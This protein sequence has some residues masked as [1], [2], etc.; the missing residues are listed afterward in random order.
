MP[1]NQPTKVK[2]PNMPPR[3]GATAL[4]EPV[5]ESQAVIA[6]RFI[7]VIVALAATAILV[8]KHLNLWSA[9]G[10]GAGGGCDK[11]ATS[12]FG[13]VAFINWPTP[14]G[15]PVSFLGFTYYLSLLVSLVVTQGKVTPVMKH[16]ARLGALA[17]AFFLFIMLAN[18]NKYFC[19]YCLASHLANF[20]FLATVEVAKNTAPKG[21]SW[22]TLGALVGAFVLTTGGLVGAELAAE[23]KR[24]SG[25]GDNIA[26]MVEIEKAKEAARQNQTPPAPPT[27]PQQTQQA[28]ST[29]PQ[30]P[31]QSTQNTQ[32]QPAPTPQSDNSEA[33]IAQA[34]N[35]VDYTTWSDDQWEQYAKQKGL[36]PG[37]PADAGPK[38]GFTGQYRIGPS[39]ATIRIVSFSDY[40]CPD[41]KKVEAQ[42]EEVLK[43]RADISF[44]H[45]HFAF[46]SACNPHFKNP[47]SPHPNSCWA[48]RA[49]E[50][51][52]LVRGNRGFWE[53]H[54]WLFSRGGAFTD[55][56]MAQA[57]RVMN[58]EPSAFQQLMKEDRFA[59]I[60]A[61]DCDEGVS[62]GLMFTP[63]VFI[64]GVELKS[65]SAMGAIRQAV[66]A[67]TAVNPAPRDAVGDQPQSAFDK[68]VSDWRDGFRFD[69][70]ILDRGGTAFP[71]GRANS[72]V[73]VIIWG[74][75]QE[76]S[77]R[78]A[79]NAI[80]DRYRGRNDVTVE[81]RH[82]PF[83][84]D[85]N[86]FAETERNEN[87]CGMA[88]AVEA[89]GQLGGVD[90]YWAMHDWIMENAKTY[91]EEAMLQKAKS[92]GL[93]PD[94]MKELMSS[95]EMSK[96][97]MRDCAN[98]K[99][100]VGARSIPC[101]IING[102]W[103]PRVELNGDLSPLVKMLEV[104]EQEA[105]L[106]SSGTSSS[107]G[108]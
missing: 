81:Y 89:A 78:R 46:N 108:R 65:W 82:Y 104:A 102:R 57:L 66:D 21:W 12:E 9:P 27:P 67:L 8:G 105:G 63:L 55:A 42:I 37:I 91:T 71:R 64:N 5:F 51:A 106:P 15:W 25:L 107:G 28:T 43:E 17:S 53:M 103:A 96:T 58:Y 20:G 95:E 36:P 54:F 99:N 69:E 100:R 94:K 16:V 49:A 101:I 19:Q 39:P 86:P 52:G 3:P 18:L 47:R 90:A 23:G 59:P 22:R 74:D 44:T 56:E 38:V 75:Y 93:D 87:S 6:L 32:S 7:A 61:A 97:I 77:T 35:G 4:S 14:E 85:C 48:S 45:K 88:Q 13:K 33:L 70:A 50:T 68:Y 29:S 79:N 1:K 76:D 41:C 83:H 84:E 73:R 11:A 10:C 31:V 30:P 34:R 40:Q 98:A 60:I 72:N 62:L 2:R 26:K 92:L 80:M 24:Q